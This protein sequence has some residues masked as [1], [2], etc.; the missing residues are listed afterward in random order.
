VPTWSP[1]QDLIAVVRPTNNVPTAHFI[2][3]AGAELRAPVPIASIGS[4]LSMAWAPEGQRLALLNLPGRNLAEAW[5]LDLRS[6]QLRRAI[7]LPAPGD[8]SGVTWTPDGRSLIIGRVE[9]E[10]EVLLIEG[11]PKR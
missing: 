9:Y 2:S 4:P 3:P 6:T 8:S 10:N 11:L 7:G 1:A 5:V